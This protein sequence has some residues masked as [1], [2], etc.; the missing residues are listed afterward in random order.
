MPTKKTENVIV[1]DHFIAEREPV[2]SWSKRAKWN[3]YPILKGVDERL[4]Y[5]WRDEQTEADCIAVMEALE[6]ALTSEA[7][8]STCRV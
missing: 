8:E 6:A 2:R 7:K 4:Q 3:I 1:S 5:A